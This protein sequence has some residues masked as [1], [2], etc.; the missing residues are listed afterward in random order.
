MQ[1]YGLFALVAMVMALV[2]ASG[3]I[4][5]QP[6]PLTWA[7]CCFRGAAALYLAAGT[8]PVLVIL[9]NL[10]PPSEN[11][12]LIPWEFGVLACAAFPFYYFNRAYMG[13]CIDDV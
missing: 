10:G 7:G 5:Q 11:D 9:G 6:K 4:V 8:A 12:W 3:S 2:V 13:G 1:P